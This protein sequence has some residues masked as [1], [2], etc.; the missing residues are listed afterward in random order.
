MVAGPPVSA[1][2]FG[3]P[4]ARKSVRASIIDVA[5]SVRGSALKKGRGLYS[6]LRDL[7]SSRLLHSAILIRPPG[8]RGAR[9][10]IRR[11]VAD[12]ASSSGPSPHGEAK[13]K[14][15]VWLRLHCADDPRQ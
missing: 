11:A 12:T 1:R 3:A 9:R 8:L 2:A 6:M 5:F 14:P 7:P 13:A 10:A 15:I 4:P